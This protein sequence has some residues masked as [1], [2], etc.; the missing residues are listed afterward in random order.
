MAQKQYPIINNFAKGELS[1]RMEGRV[2]I[3][4]YYN[5]CKIMKN[6]IMVAQGGAE[7]RPGTIYLDEVYSSG[8]ISTKA[9]L[10]PFEVSDTEVYIL[11]VGHYA[12]RIWDV[13]GKKLVQD[14]G[15]DLILDT[16]YPSKDVSSIQYATTEGQIF[17]AHQ[18][19]AFLY[20]K[21]TNEGFSMTNQ[22]YKVEDHEAISYKRD[23]VTYYNQEYFR[24]LKTTSTAAPTKGEWIAQGSIGCTP[25]GDLSE[26]VGANFTTGDIILHKGK[27]YEA[28]RTYNNWTSQEC[29]PESE[30]QEEAWS[31]WSEAKVEWYWNTDLQCTNT[32]LG[33]CI[34]RESPQSYMNRN[35]VTS[36][37]KIQF[38]PWGGVGILG[39]WVRYQL[40]TLSITS[41]KEE[42]PY[43][44]LKASVPLGTETTIIKTWVT[45]TYNQDEIVYHPTT[46]IM[47]KCLEDGTTGDPGVSPEWELL[48]NNPFFAVE[49][50]FPAAVAFMGQRLYL[51]G[52]ASH[53]QTV[54]GSKIGRYDNFNV[55]TDDDDAF[56]FEI[57]SDRSSRIKWMVG[58]DQLM[59]GTTSSEWIVTGGGVG[60][61]PTN[62]Q[63]LKQS[64]YGSAY[65]QA[66]QVADTLL[67]YQKGGRKLREYM[68]SNDN[69]AYLANDLTFF[70]DHI[71]SP[72][73]DESSYQ[74]N[75]DSILWSTKINGGLIGLTY[76]RLN[77]IA[78]WHRH[79]TDGVFE[80]VVSVDGENEE[81]ELWFVVR[82]LV[83]GVFKRYVEHMAPRLTNTSTIFSDSASIHSAGDTFSL[84]AITNNTSSVE[85]SYI[86]KDGIAEGDDIK[87]YNTG[88]GV[89]DHQVFQVADLV[90]GTTTGTFNLNK[91]GNLF[92]TTDMTVI[93]SG[94]FAIVTD[95]I[96]GLD[97]L[98]GKTVMVLGD[99]AIFPPQE[100]VSD[101]DGN[102][103]VGIIISTP[104]NSIV[105]GLQYEMVIQPE[106]IEVP[107][108]STMSATRRI[109]KATLKL[110]NSLGGFV[111]TNV[112]NM[113][114]I[115]YRS[116]DLPFGIAPP[117]FTGTKDIPIDAESGKES[118][119]YISNK[120][121]LPMTILA[122]TTDISYSRS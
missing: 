56:Y 52:T 122:I 51:G 69:K 66:S 45:A 71:T 26:W 62:V 46:Y 77:N 23:E 3:Q 15:S 36:T 39:G 94:G 112:E 60:I 96:I 83:N 107:G 99:Q 86:G 70:A 114:E 118:T 100:V 22:L 53:P 8:A 43:W 78:G 25:T 97:H 64:A 17:L 9:K 32:I 72:G 1:S 95:T 116:T 101:V 74:Q 91:N 13:Y 48:S 10:I 104:C 73:I 121:P 85:I 103:G 31:D 88:S 27:I 89:Y 35:F 6:C 58:K 92:T 87:V 21:K 105:C 79:D 102:G 20:I 28:Q 2:D 34:Q 14:S 65:N 84:T 98:L 19:H 80:S 82:R 93:N 47:Y 38:L 117:F 50:D 63:V 40:S 7:K 54:F 109:S 76:D 37:Q 16:P 113:K 5:G 111:G 115:R 81:D 44:E 106:S 29:W 120:Q 55:G 108:S 57:A 67:F 61:T 30:I 49:G 59:I 42:N 4:G 90:Q 24:A 12:T 33:I 110:Y 119:I 11:E 18:N 68:Y 75:P 41:S